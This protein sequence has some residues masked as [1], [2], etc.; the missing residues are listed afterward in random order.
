MNFF[1]GQWWALF[2]WGGIVLGVAYLVAQALPK[3]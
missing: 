1:G 3:A 2:F